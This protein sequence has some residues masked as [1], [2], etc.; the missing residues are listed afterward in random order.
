VLPIAIPVP[1]GSAHSDHD[2]F[3]TAKSTTTAS[4]ATDESLLLGVVAF[5]AFAYSM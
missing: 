3:D 2:S 1:N 4:T 5:Q